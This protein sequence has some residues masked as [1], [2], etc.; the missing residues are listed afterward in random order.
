LLIWIPSTLAREIKADTQEILNDT[1]AIKQDT[2]Q[3]LAE[4]ARLQEQLPR[5]ENRRSAGFMLE[6]YL[7]NLTSYAETVFDPFLDGSDKSRPT[8][9]PTSSGQDMTFNQ[10]GPHSPISPRYLEIEFNH[11]EDSE[12]RAK[13]TRGLMATLATDEEEEAKGYTDKEMSEIEEK[14]RG[15]T[16]AEDEEHYRKSIAEETPVEG[17]ELAAES[18]DIAVAQLRELELPVQSEAVAKPGISNEL[19]EQ[20]KAI[21]IGAILVSSIE[22]DRPSNISR[23]S[24]TTTLNSPSLRRNILEPNREPIFQHKDAETSED[25]QFKLDECEQP[26]VDDSK[27]ENEP[28]AAKEPHTQSDARKPERSQDGASRELVVIEEPFVNDAANGGNFLVPQTDYIENEVDCSLPDMSWGPEHIHTIFSWLNETSI[29]TIAVSDVDNEHSFRVSEAQEALATEDLVPFDSS[30]KSDW[31]DEIPSSNISTWE[32]DS[33]AHT[34]I[35]NTG[36]LEAIV[37]LRRLVAYA[38]SETFSARMLQADYAP[39]PDHGESMR[40]YFEAM[41]LNGDKSLGM[42]DQ[43]LKIDDVHNQAFLQAITGLI[44]DYG[45][46]REK[47]H[48]L[49]EASEFLVEGERELR[50]HIDS[51]RQSLIAQ[52][53]ISDALDRGLRSLRA[54]SK[55][56]RIKSMQDEQMIKRIRVQVARMKEYISRDLQKSLGFQKSLGAKYSGLLVIEKK[57]LRKR[58]E[59]SRE[60][61]VV[62][63]ARQ[64]LQMTY[65]GKDVAQQKEPQNDKQAAIK[66]QKINI[67]LGRAHKTSILIEHSR[68]LEFYVQMVEAEVAQSLVHVI[69]ENAKGGQKSSSSKTHGR[70]PREKKDGRSIVARFG[71]GSKIVEWDPSDSFDIPIY[72]KKYDLDTNVIRRDLFLVFRDIGIRFRQYTNLPSPKPELEIRSWFSCSYLPNSYPASGN[73]NF[74]AWQGKPTTFSIYVVYIKREK[75]HIIRSRFGAGSDHKKLIEKIEAKLSIHPAPFHGLLHSSN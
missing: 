14:G 67:R 55:A 45:A 44:D 73:L 24:E 29:E 13:I 49:L 28:F 57:I 26:V 40:K 60:L 47:Y 61:G 38:L 32:L 25:E 33:D 18:I 39:G 15:R 56:E 68:A 53:R 46:L 10:Y 75:A 35:D 37:S 22:L 62:R 41:T 72:C 54:T 17:V 34:E 51:N 43:G 23:L 42:D 31:T 36:S 1:S 69:G 21:D 30:A 11:D 65:W 58:Q 6:R 3:I 16:D 50:N 63:E 27:E 20:P 8:S 48:S 59:V 9:R 5:G 64:K 4:I 70:R 52:H 71:R 2:A 66:P 7:D 74:K 19:R 12:T